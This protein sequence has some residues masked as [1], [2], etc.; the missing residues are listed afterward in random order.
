MF[1]KD[2]G[3]I[4]LG[5]HSRSLPMGRNKQHNVHCKF[6]K[7]GNFIPVYVQEII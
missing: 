3:L 7:F 2:E 6:Q 1:W 4:F 5:T